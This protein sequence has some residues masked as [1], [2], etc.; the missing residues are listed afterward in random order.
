MKSFYK[1]SSKNVA[2]IA[3]KSMVMLKV[4]KNYPNF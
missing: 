3:L 4:V 2:V 1:E